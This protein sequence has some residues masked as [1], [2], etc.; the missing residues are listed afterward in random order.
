MHTPNRDSRNEWYN[1]FKASRWKSSATV[2][3]LIVL[4]IFLHVIWTERNLRVFNATKNS[5]AKLYALTIKD[6]KNGLINSCFD[7]E[8]G[9]KVA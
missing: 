1:I 3:L 4:K 8:F 7:L 5:K 9:F 6:N 2:T